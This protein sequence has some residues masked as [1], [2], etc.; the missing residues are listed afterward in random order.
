MHIYGELLIGGGSKMRTKQG[1]FLDKKEV[2][3]W[4]RIM[5]EHRRNAMKSITQPIEDPKKNTQL[6]KFF[7]LE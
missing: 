1:P 6:T 7:E 2:S 4:D 3:E 5:N